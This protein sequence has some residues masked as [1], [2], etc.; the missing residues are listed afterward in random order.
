M[1]FIRQSKANKKKKQWENIF[2]LSDGTS[3]KIDEVI[4]DISTQNTTSNLE[5][6]ANENTRFILL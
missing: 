4:N 3:L 2:N 1:M 5:N 6:N